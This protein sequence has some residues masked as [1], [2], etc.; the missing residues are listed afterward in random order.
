MDKLVLHAS[1]C[2]QLLVYL[3]LENQFNKLLCNICLL[4]VLCGCA[5]TNTEDLSATV[6]FANSIGAEF[7]LKS[8]VDAYGIYID[9]NERKVAYISVIFGYGIS[10]PEVAF[11]RL[12]PK[13]TILKVLYAKRNEIFFFRAKP[14]LEVTTSGSLFPSGIPIRIAITDEVAEPNF[15]LDPSVY[16]RVKARSQ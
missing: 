15:G 13:G 6:R 11:K 10:G 7:Q 16:M 5:P 8:D 2:K 12:I 1:V 4:G 3:N 9:L 14:F